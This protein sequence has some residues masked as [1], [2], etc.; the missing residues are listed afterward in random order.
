MK[1]TA[2]SLAIV[3]APLA[4]PAYA[5]TSAVHEQAARMLANVCVAAPSMAGRENA[6]A[7]CQCA[8]ELT[9]RDGSERQLTLFTRVFTYYPDQTAAAA[10]LRRMMDEEG[11]TREDY[12]AVGRLLENAVQIVDDQCGSAVADLVGPGQ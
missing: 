7:M 12:L 10:E 1:R 2:L 3:L 4:A 8:G 11:Y 6:Q 5:E 9:V